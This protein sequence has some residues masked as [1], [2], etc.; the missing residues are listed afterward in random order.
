M[1]MPMKLTIS[2]SELAVLRLTYSL[3]SLKLLLAVSYLLETNQTL[4]N[5]LRTPYL[6]LTLN[7]KRRKSDH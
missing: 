4:P 5:Q 7:P 1:L 2:N 3:E 6:E